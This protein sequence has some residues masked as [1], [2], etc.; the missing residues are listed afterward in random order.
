MS[1]RADIL[2]NNYEAS[3]IDF[4]GAYIRLWVSFN[5]WYNDNSRDA[6]EVARVLA[7]GNARKLR[8]SYESDVDQLNE[9][10][11]NDNYLHIIET[12]ESHSV[13]TYTDS[14]GTLLRQERTRRDSS[15]DFD[16]IVRTNTPVFSWPAVKTR[17][18]SRGVRALRS[19]IRRLARIRFSAWST[20]DT[21]TP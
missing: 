16:A 4:V 17:F 3:K 20:V 15:T 13:Y 1:M 21:G 10:A 11:H 9:P 12:V 19:S 2:Q 5:T 8:D 14:N 18:F 7:A 6:S